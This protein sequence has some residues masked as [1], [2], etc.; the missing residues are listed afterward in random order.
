ML[1]AGEL[2]DTSRLYHLRA[3]DYDAVAG[4]FAQV[5]PAEPSPED[6]ALATYHYGG[7][8]PL[9]MVDPSGEDHGSNRDGTGDGASISGLANRNRRVLT[10][11]PIQGDVD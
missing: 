8:R 10:Y 1:L 6:P 11:E 3:R 5:D 9:V 7:N 4:R 2:Q